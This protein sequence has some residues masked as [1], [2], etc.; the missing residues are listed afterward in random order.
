MT[1]VISLQGPMA[2]GKTTLAKRLEKRG[3]R[4]IYENPYPIV[5]KRKKLNLDMNSKVGFIMNQKMFMEA[6]IKEFQNVKDSVV[7]FDRGP[8]DIEFFTLF[9]PT[10]IGEEWDIETELKDELYKLR[11]CRSDVIFYLDV[12]KKNVYDRKNNDRTRNRSTF[13]EQFKLAE[14]EKDWY[15][16]FPVTYVDTN[17]LT[18]DDLEV[19]FMDWLKERGL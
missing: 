12:T 6:K 5:E 14:T 10:I 13:E 3:F 17:R 2:S 19:Y 8:E 11:E 18:V 4:V 7:I 15:K 1:Y 9:Y 16:Q